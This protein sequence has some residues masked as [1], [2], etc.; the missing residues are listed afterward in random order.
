VEFRASDMEIRECAVNRAQPNLLS[1]GGYDRVVS[2]CDLNAPAAEPGGQAGPRVLSRSPVDG[3]VS[4][5][6]CSPVFQ[7]RYVRVT[8]DQGQFLLLDR[9][10][11]NKRSFGFDTDPRHGPLY[12]HEFVNANLAVLGFADKT[13]ELRDL[14]MERSAVCSIED[15]YV[16]AVGDLQFNSQSGFLLV[17]GLTEYEQLQAFT[18]E[19]LP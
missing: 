10:M 6:K 9:R 7:Q 14:R 2:F 19:L 18:I 4:G 17:S 15:P 12:A 11:G 13:I 5:L 8:T 1:C 16:G 3:V